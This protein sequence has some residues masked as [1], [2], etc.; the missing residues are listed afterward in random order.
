MSVLSGLL[1]SNLSMY[2]ILNVKSQFQ[3]FLPGG[4]GQIFSIERKA[5]SLCVWKAGESWPSARK[6]QPDLSVTAALVNEQSLDL[7]LSELESQFWSWAP[8]EE[9]GFISTRREAWSSSVSGQNRGDHQR[10]RSARTV[11]PGCFCLRETLM[12]TGILKEK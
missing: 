3:P 10:L 9:I 6:G 2:R 11:C 7:G 1:G 5:R 4:E 12:Y 8:G